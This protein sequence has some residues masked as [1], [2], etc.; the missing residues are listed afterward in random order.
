MD[1]DGVLKPLIRCGI[2]NA[3]IYLCWHLRVAAVRGEQQSGVERQGGHEQRHQQEARGAVGADS[4]SGVA[5]QVPAR[6]VGAG[7]PL[8]PTSKNMEWWRR[9]NIRIVLYYLSEI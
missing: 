7:D 8:I 1:Q 9:I 2:L 5:A 4:Y 6:C 3:D